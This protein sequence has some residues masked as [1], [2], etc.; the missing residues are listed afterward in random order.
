MTQTVP[1]RKR[2]GT[3]STSEIKQQQVVKLRAAGASQRAIS[4]EVGLARHTVKRILS[5][6][7]YQLMVQRGRSELAELVPRATGVLAYFLKR[8]KKTD[9]VADVAIAILNGLQVFVP[10]TRTNVAVEQPNEF[11]GWSKEQILEYIHTGK[12]PNEEEF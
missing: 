10:K 11:E 9:K 4:R 1:P 7:E 2:K 8:K 3:L 6:G 5:Q 12:K